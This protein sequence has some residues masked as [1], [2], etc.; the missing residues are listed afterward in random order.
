MKKIVLL[1][2]ILLMASLMFTG[3]SFGATKLLFWTAPNPNQE[4]FWKI[5]VSDWK[6]LHPETEIEWRVIPAGRSSEEVILTAIATG[7]GPDICTNIFGGFAAELIESRTVIPLTDFPDFEKLVALRHMENAIKGWEFQGKH[8]VIPLYCNPC[9]MWWR[10]DFLKELG[11][12]PPRTY[13]ELYS[14]AEKFVKPKEKYLFQMGTGLKWW[15][16]WFDF[17]NYYYAASGGQPYIDTSTKEATFDNKSGKAVAEFAY[18]LFKNE[19]AALKYAPNPFQEG[20]VLGGFVGPWNLRKTEESWPEVYKNLIITPP[21]VPDWFPKDKPIY[22][23][24]DTK[25][26]VIFSNSKHQKE[27][28]EFTKW[29]FSD[30]LHDLLWLQLTRMPVARDDLATNITFQWFLET[31][32][33]LAMYCAN[34][35]S[36]LPTA[37]T[38]KTV[39][40]QEAMTYE[41][42]EPLMHTLK[43]PSNAIKDAQ[44]AVTKASQAK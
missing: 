44:K 12:K 41:M 8:Y 5:L 15:D 22:S 4:L 19:W 13:E 1:G 16:R 25:G 11:A 29:V 7:T 43:T 23:Y 26:L 10:G 35:G 34:V 32:P 28:W 18:T 6:A 37:L 14:L 2:V 39:D 20:V 17:I 40:I 42:W 21:L 31:Q 38:T 33:K 36:A 27:A 3:A 9:L 30:P 24:A